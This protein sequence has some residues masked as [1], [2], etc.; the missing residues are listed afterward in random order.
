VEEL[1]SHDVHMH[2]V[3]GICAIDNISIRDCQIIIIKI[4]PLSDVHG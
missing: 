3:A 2:I 4:N 1:A